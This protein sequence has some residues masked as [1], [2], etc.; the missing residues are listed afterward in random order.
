MLSI[1]IKRRVNLG[2]LPGIDASEDI[3]VKFQSF[4]MKQLD[5]LTCT[6]AKNHF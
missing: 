2:K 1:K 6:D 5:P 4:K 3:L